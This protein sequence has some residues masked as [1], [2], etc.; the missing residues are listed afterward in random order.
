LR[1]YQRHKN[2]KYILPHAVYH[3]T[4]WQIRDYYRL[5][6]EADGIL[7]ESTPPSD[8]MP[9]GTAISDPVHA[10]A[11]R[12]ETALRIVSIID[13]ELTLIPSEYR[14]GIWESV[15]FRKRYPDDADRHTYGRWRARFIYGVARQLFPDE[16]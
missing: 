11:V 10:K 3:K 16:F 5:K 6:T 7:V 15:Q 12:R 1:D 9:R 14:K 8:G 13:R 4:L 2:N